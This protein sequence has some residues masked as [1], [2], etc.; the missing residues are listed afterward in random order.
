MSFFHFS[1]QVEEVGQY[2]VVAGI[3]V[4]AIESDLKSAFGTSVIFSRVITRLSARSF[5]IHRFFM[6]EFAWIL[7]HL[8]SQRN[9]RTVDRYRVGMLKYKQLFDE[10]KEKTWI[11]S[12]YEQY[13]TYDIDKALKDF[14]V[15]PYGDQREFLEDYSRIKYGYRLKG[16]LLDAATGSGKSI[17]SL[18]WSAMI[19][20]HKTFI[21]CPRNLITT[22]WLLEIDKAFKTPK[23]VWTSI[24]GT[25]ILD[26]TDADIFII[27]KEQLRDNN[28]D[29]AIRA[30]TKN[31]KEP[32]K[33]IVDES[34]NFNEPNSQQSSGLISFGRNPNISDV[35]LMSGTPIKAQGKETYTL[36]FNR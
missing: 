30:I 25:N 34:H 18:I 5:R 17:C 23:K 13:P 28:W 33:L 21:I 32:A 29:V 10:V 35:L 3:N 15:T 12:T 26:H 24:D 36:C 9:K 22:P 11:K 1:P 4:Q 20:K 27:H 7:E 19:S 14:K 2:Y 16:C 8:T 6:V 31:G